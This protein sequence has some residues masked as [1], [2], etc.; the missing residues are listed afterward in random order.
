MTV[1]TPAT[2]PNTPG[3]PRFLIA[4]A[5]RMLYRNGIDSQVAGH[6]SL[7]VP[8]EE[9][10][11]VSPSEYFDETLPHHILKVSFDLEV[12]EQ[13]PFPPQPG[14]NFH[15]DIYRAR[16]DVNCII[17][18]HGL[19]VSIV[20]T[21]GKPP[22]PYHAYGALFQDDVVLFHDDPNIT[23][24]KEGP[25]LAAALADKRALLIANHGIIHAG[26]TI[27]ETTGEALML[28]FAASVQIKAMRLGGKPMPVET[29]RTYRGL[30]LEISFRR[31]LWD[32]NLRRLEKSDPDLFAP[33]VSA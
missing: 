2:R 18:T 3:D 7:R 31:D 29:A 13:G 21:L 20:S 22:E 5:R 10:F 1:Q 27:E 19:N 8:G 33:A 26:G 25:K 28:D 4:A 17:H 15:A 9:A 24:D 23:P 12:L 30:Y 16:P 6:I 14:I 11:L 32:A